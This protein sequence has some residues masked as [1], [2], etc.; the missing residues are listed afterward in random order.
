M[1]ILFRNWS[2]VITFLLTILATV[3]LTFHWLPDHLDIRQLEAQLEAKRLFLAQ[4]AEMSEKA[5]A[6]QQEL[7]RTE[8]VTAKWNKTSSHNKNILALYERI[9]ALAKDDCLKVTR[10][11]PQPPIKYESLQEI[12]LSI[13]CSGRFSEIYDFLRDLEGLPTTMR[14]NFVKMEKKAGNEKDVECELGLM[15]FSDYLLDPALVVERGQPSVA[16]DSRK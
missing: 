16:G 1:N 6:L 8:T 13:V 5:A 15:V 11:A 2:W 9:D 3:Y 10:F 12:P 14:V 7:V 4:S